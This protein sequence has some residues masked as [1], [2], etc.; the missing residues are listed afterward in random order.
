MPC[1]AEIAYIGVLTLRRRGDE[2]VAGLYVSVDKSRRM[3]CIDRPGDLAN[4]AEC[5]LWLER[6]LAA[7]KLAQ[8]RPLDV[9]HRKVE[10]AVL[11]A[12][13]EDR[14]DMRVIEARGEL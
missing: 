14:D 8:V 12:G 6:A 3:C 11:L 2:D 4:K 13:I 5:A 7:K 1:Q 10:V 9:R